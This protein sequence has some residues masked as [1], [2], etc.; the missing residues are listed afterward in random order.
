VSGR[1]ARLRRSLHEIGQDFIELGISQTMLRPD[2]GRL[3][4]RGK[5][6]A[7]GLI[8]RLFEL[9]FLLGC[10]L[11]HRL[12]LSGELQ[13]N[14]G[15]I[16]LRFGGKAAHDIDGVQAAGSYASIPRKPRAGE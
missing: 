9:G 10:Q 5:F 16:V 14:A 4:V 8:E 11:N 7:L 2:G 1:G 3:F 12:I 6:A 13:E 15:K